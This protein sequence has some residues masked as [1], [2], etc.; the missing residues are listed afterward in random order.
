MRTVLCYGDSNTWGCEPG[1]GAR[2]PRDV[3]WP[4]LLQAA[5]GDA[6]HVVEEGL[7]GRTAT[8]DSPIMPGKNGLEYLIPC[9]ASHAPLDAVV[10]FLGTNDMADRYSL[11]AMEVARCA[12]RLAADVRRV[13]VAGEHCVALGWSLGA[14]GPKRHAGTAVFAGDELVGAATAVWVE[15]RPRS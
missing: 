1:T 9:L 2:Y 8:L 4:G 12:G 10:I 13:P 14:E 15:P 3:R 6:W 11:S 7:G 5:L